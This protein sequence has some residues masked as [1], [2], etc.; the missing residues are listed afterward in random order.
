MGQKI[1]IYFSKGGNLNLDGGSLI[2]TSRLYGQPDFLRVVKACIHIV[3]GIL[4][5]INSHSKVMHKHDAVFIAVPQVI[6]VKPKQNI[7][8]W[9]ILKQFL[10][11]PVF[12]KNI[13]WNCIK[14]A[15]HE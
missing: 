2:F 11:A 10:V 1:I 4:S 15:F 13:S 6:F 14:N 8:W 7:F 12:P 5:F 9:K 3:I